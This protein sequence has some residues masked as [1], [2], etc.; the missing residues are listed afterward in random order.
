MHFQH[1]C[2]KCYLYDYD[3]D[4]SFVHSG[5]ILVGEETSQVGTGSRGEEPDAEDSRVCQP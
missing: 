5:V 2:T 4:V 3:Y 1:S